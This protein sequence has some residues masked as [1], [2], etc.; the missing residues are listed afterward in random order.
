MFIGEI[1]DIFCE[2]MIVFVNVRMVKDDFVI[3][4]LDCGIEGCIE[5]YEV[6][7]SGG[8]RDFFSQGQIL[9]VK[10]KVMNYKDFM[11][12]LSL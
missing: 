4:K 11:V 9:Q 5:F 12:N 6:D 2:G 3:V 1:K 8:L 7:V 10:I